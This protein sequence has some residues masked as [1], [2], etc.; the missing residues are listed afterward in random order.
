M[1][2][3]DAILA[4]LRRLAGMF[5]PAR[6]AAPLALV[7]HDGAGTGSLRDALL[8]GDRTGDMPAQ[9]REPYGRSWIDWTPSGIRSAE[10]FANG[11][12]LRLAADLADCMMADDR[13]QTTLG[14]RILGLLGLPLTFSPGMGRRR[15]RAQRA[16]EAEEDW[17]TLCPEHA[18]AQVIRW[19][20]VLGVGLGQLVY[21]EGPVEPGKR[22]VPTL[23]AWHPRWLR[24]DWPS[25][26]WRLK[27]DDGAREITI[28]PGDGEWFLFLPY[29]SS[30]PWAF[31][32]WRGLSRWYLFK[33]FAIDDWGLH[34]EVHGQPLRIAKSA[35]ATTP[36][37]RRELAAQLQALGRETA[38]ALP[39]GFDLELVEATARTWEMFSRQ[40]ELADKAFAVACLGGNLGTD[41]A[42]G[43]KTGAT[44]QSAIREDLRRFDGEN[45]STQ[46]HDQILAWWA[47]YNF[48]DRDAAPWAVWDATPPED[49]QATAGTWKTVA[50]T[51]ATLKTSGWTVDPAD[52]EARFG[53]RL[54]PL[55]PP[56]P[57][58]PALPPATT[59]PAEEAA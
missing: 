39:D 10:A 33:Q 5:R 48:G 28:T 16:L 24:W 41:T 22:L 9:A 32:L 34:S 26:E 1:R 14:T 51:L 43:Q 49:Q 59:P 38:F 46:T 15:G 19:G 36:Q 52:I 27:V 4:P 44:A 29:G 47:E 45:L 6:I 42:D 30:R 25:R 23:K 13:L 18:L 37:L 2:L 57:T 50:D 7:G 58:P 56:E 35:K 11:G 55:A 53:L 54:V 17:W 8:R 12:N 31:G 21:P 3:L 20:L 40:I